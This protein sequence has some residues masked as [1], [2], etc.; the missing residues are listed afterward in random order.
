[1]SDWVTVRPRNGNVSKRYT[2]GS[3]FGAASAYAYRN[4][5]SLW[6]IGKAGYS[7]LKSL[8]LRGGSGPGTPKYKSPPPPY[9]SGKKMSPWRVDTIMR[10]RAVSTSRAV[11]TQ[12]N[13]GYANRSLGGGGNVRRIGKRRKFRVSKKTFD[14]KK[15]LQNGNTAIQEVRKT[16]SNP[17][18]VYFGHTVSTGPLLGVIAKAIT[19]RLAVQL[20]ATIR[21]WTD[22]LVVQLAGDHHI[23]YI[24]YNS[25]D[26]GGITTH[27]QSFAETLTWELVAGTIQNLL[28]Y[29]A[30]ADRPFMIKWYDLLPNPVTP[31]TPFY[32][33][34][35]TVNCSDLRLHFDMTSK[36]KFQNQTPAG[37]SE[38]GRFET[39]DIGANPLVGMKYNNKKWA[40]GFVRKNRGLTEDA[41]TA[42]NFSIM[43][44][45]NT[46]FLSTDLTFPTNTGDYFQKPPPAREFAATGSKVRMS[47]GEVGY[48]VQKFS[49]SISL[50]NLHIK[51]PVL[52]SND[53]SV[54]M[55][56]IAP[57][58]FAE[59][60]SFE[61][62]IDSGSEAPVSIGVQLDQT[63]RCYVTTIRPPI[64][65]KVFVQ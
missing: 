52:L 43:A 19:A 8:R 54:D 53:T 20:G 2:K 31:A 22:T 9:A 6:K 16:V 45:A 40:N 26:V 7:A 59:L 42:T 55:K 37:T 5:K 28:A 47:P 27:Q 24:K 18:C 58:G 60:Y 48:S 30:A 3:H 4:R 21:D 23:E 15:N 33:L 1:M 65:N 17:E 46:G 10:P 57:F 63:Y 39:T 25:P 61:K 62:T 14:F 51:W 35:A 13:V 41:T 36:L 49:C 34:R 38:S 11:A 32:L 56:V 50:L 29:T 44:E 12:T 64:N